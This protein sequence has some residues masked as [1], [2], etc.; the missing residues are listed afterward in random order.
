MVNIGLCLLLRRVVARLS[1][2]QEYC[3]Q[4]DVRRGAEKEIIVTAT[5]LERY[6]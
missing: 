1:A 2:Q 4:D 3:S 5:A 6:I